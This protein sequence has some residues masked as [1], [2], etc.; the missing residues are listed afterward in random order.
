MN[1]KMKVGR[2][3]RSVQ[4]STVGSTVSSGSAFRKY[5]PTATG[6][7]VWSGR[8][9]FIFT[10]ASVAV[11]FGY[12][13][14]YLLTESENELTEAQF[15]S[16]ADR[17]IYS[18]KDNLEKKRLGTVSLA[19]VI[20]GANPDASQWP[21]ASLNNF[22]N[23]ANN[24]VDV[25]KGCRMAFAP[26]VQADQLQSFEDFAYDYYEHSRMPEP[27]PNGT[28]VSASFGKGVWSMDNEMQAYKETDGTTFW[29]SSN[30]VIAPMLYHN[31]GASSKLLMNM[32][33]SPNLGQMMDDMMICAEEKASEG[34]PLDECFTISGMALDKTSWTQG[35]ESGPGSTIMQPVY[36]S[37]DPA[38][39]V[40]VIVSAIVWGEIMM[41]TYADA[42]SGV[43]LVLEAGDQVYTYTVYNGNATFQGEGDLHE[44]KFDSFATSLD[45]TS[46]DLFDLASEHYTVTLYP[47]QE[48]YDVYSTRNPMIATIGSVFIIVFT[49]LLFLVYD[50]F[51][52]REFNAK[53]EL[54]DAKRKFVR[55]V[56][57]EVRTPLNSVTMGLTLMK[58]DIAARLNKGKKVDNQKE[59]QGWLNLSEEVTAN[60]LSAVDVLNDFL[61][62]DKV[63][64][65]KL[66]LDHSVVPIFELIESTVSEFKLPAMKK[67]I[68]MVVESPISKDIE[69]KKLDFSRGQHVVGDKVRLTQV[70]R[71]LVSNA[72]KFTPE[73]GDITVRVIW[74]PPTEKELKRPN[75]DSFSLSHDEKW[76]FPRAG[77][78]MLTVTDN[79]AGMTPEQVKS[80]FQQGTQ[81]NV[82]EL[83]AGCGSGLGTYIAKGIVRQHGG[84]LS[85]FS[86]GLNKGS[87]FSVSLPVHRVPEELVSTTKT[88]NGSDS[89]E[90]DIGHLK[91]LVVDDAKTNLKLLM[92]LLT[93]HGHICEGAEDGQIA[94]EK[95]QEAMNAGDEF[96]A[97]LMDYQ[98][99]VMDGPT[100]STKLREIGCDAF[101]VGVT[102]NVM[103]EDV[104]F[105]KDAGANTVLPKPIKL[106]DLDALFVE[107]GVRAEPAGQ[108]TFGTAPIN[109][110]FSQ[111]GIVEGWETTEAQEPESPSCRSQVLRIDATGR[112]A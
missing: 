50:I 99:P 89:E 29:G 66:T 51:V 91:I 16:I 33:F 32:H 75:I 58:E 106:S 82:N 74:V 43:D 4:H 11:T 6:R 61:N 53:K 41:S 92:R 59:L 96:D 81:F 94:V 38:K 28:A 44:T 108:A 21:F 56:S 93:K 26:F 10:L 112:V 5:L 9:A 70:F 42:V 17:A 101:I 30:Q 14:Y 25:S 18:T 22:E 49:S 8:I 65:G 40:G 72:I 20:G 47:T 48:L 76:E 63:E 86:E 88:A 23:I 80:V 71:N 69:G 34:R 13:S 55:F 68:K 110:T 73:Q 36:A 104:R 7:A 37:N 3:D 78:I 27:F 105:F 52:R 45:I 46:K 109:L 103:P 107:H 54:L 111:K 15:A 100:A 83:Q 57:H 24:L 60:A 31:T 84:Q 39:L 102:G 79:G 64:T 77:S 62:Y 85:A 90:D 1:M 67:K 95:A 98:M 97:I 2:G 35:A 12:L 19:S 87:T